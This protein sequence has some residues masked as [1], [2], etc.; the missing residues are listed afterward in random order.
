VDVNF[1]WGE[2][3]QMDPAELQGRLQADIGRGV[4]PVEPA[5]EALRFVRQPQR[6]QHEVHV[7]HAA[8]AVELSNGIRYAEVN[9]EPPG[10]RPGVLDQGAELV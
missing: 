7:D 10:V 3:S 5:P 6:A 8:G 9:P 4:A 2:I 1:N